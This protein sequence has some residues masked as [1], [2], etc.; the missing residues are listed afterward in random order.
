MSVLQWFNAREAAATGASLA[1]ELDPKAAATLMAAGGKATASALQ[2]FLERAERIVG[3]LEL[4]FYKRAK[5]ANSFKWRLLEKGVDKPTADAVTNA[6]VMHLLTNSSDATAYSELDD[7][8]T[9]PDSSGSVK[10]LLVRGNACFARGEYSEALS[11][12][13]KL[14]T[15]KPRHADALNNIGATLCRLNRFHEAQDYLQRA[16]K[17]R[18]EFPE[19]LFCLGVVQNWQGL[20]PEAERSLRRALKSKPSHADARSLLGAVLAFEGRLREAEIQLGKALKIDPRNADAMVGMGEVAR[21]DG[22]FADAESSFR[23]ALAI[24]PSMPG[25]WAALAM[26]RKMSVSDGAWLDRASEIAASGIPP[27]GEAALRFSIGKYHDDIGEYARAF[28]SYRQANDL[29]RSVARP[30]SRDAHEHFVDDLIRVQT[31]EA[32]L[33]LPD[34]G[35]DSARPV[36]IVGML[37]SGSTLA[38]QIIA[39]HPSAKGA[40]EQGFW[41]NA[42]RKYEAE[43]RSG[44]LDQALRAKLA[45]DY[46]GVLAAASSDALRVV[47]K[48]LINADYLGVIHSVFPNARI[49]YM[50]RN[51]IDTCLSCYFQ[52]F[53]QAFT[54]SLDLSDLAQYYRQHHRLMA[55]WRK[56][57]P[58]GSILDVPYEGLVADQRA[59][60]ARMLE[61]IGLEWDD[62]CLDFQKTDRAVGTASAWQVRQR[63]YQDSV[64]RWRHYEKFIKPLMS[65]Q[66]LDD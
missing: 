52:Q 4:N 44:P 40:G 3:A 10:Q 61:F 19:A 35:S 54:F 9:E 49:I 22:R 42:G 48:A 64:A 17:L 8:S 13:E 38:E 1:D 39:S 6:L 28:E 41:S 65:L 59:W 50:K 47:D 56:V 2:D 21:M 18:P 23:R 7:A 30:Y 20:Y 29:A 24:N 55:H 58:P 34:A 12:Y 45:E 66:H 33:P 26:L 16:I 57:L 27:T 15:L 31:R 37:R 46:L 51:P 63:I 53:S 11:L 5:L 60:T 36:F 62:R 25:A 32:I 14:A 43:I